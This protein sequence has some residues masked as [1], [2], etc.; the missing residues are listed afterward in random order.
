[1]P[2][3]LIDPI[4]RIF[5]NASLRLEAEESGRVRV[6]F[7]AYGYRGMEE[8]A[9][10]AHLENLLPVV[11]RICGVDSLFHQVAASLAVEKALGLEASPD[12]RDLRALALW[13]QLFER[14]A[15]SLAVHSLPDLLFPASDP[16]LRNL[17]SIY[18]VAEDV[19][20]RL[21]GLK[22]LGTTVLREVGGAA[23]HPMNFRPAGAARDISQEVRRGLVGKLDEARPLLAEM[24][25]QVKLSLRRN[26]DL[27]NQTGDTPT[28][29]LSLKGRSGID[30]EEGSPA[31]LSPE[32]AGPISLSVEELQEKLQEENSPCSHVRYAGLEGVGEVT[33]GPLARIN[34]NGRYGSPWADEELEELKAHW[35]FPV[36]KCLLGHALRVL[37]MI[38]AWERMVA[39]LEGPPLEDIKAVVRPA[40]GEA[41]AMLE[42]PEGSLVYVIGIS[43]EGLVEKLSIFSPLQFNLRSLERSLLEIHAVLGG[44]E[45]EGKVEDLLQ[46][47]VRAYA[48]CIPCGVR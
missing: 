18:R 15:I 33:V 21:L 20:R 3:V 2:E 13:A 28:T 23:V 42:A 12:L 11:S 17:V 26:E 46:M 34:V 24:A 48:P 9:R 6:C 25:R 16:G 38:H 14:H 44:S 19:V 7:R 40:A 39:L 8:I 45:E 41:V 27:V 29:C 43:G 37:E 10:G 5:G 36:H 47:V 4:T 31:L 30:V 32:A 35:G 22:S 1:M